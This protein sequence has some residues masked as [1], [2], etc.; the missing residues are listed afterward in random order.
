MVENEEIIND[1]SNG[2]LNVGRTFGLQEAEG[3]AAVRILSDYTLRIL[4]PKGEDLEEAHIRRRI[5][6]V[7]QAVVHSLEDHSLGDH[8]LEFC[9]PSAA[10]RR[11]HVNERY[12]CARKTRLT[13]T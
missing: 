3:R 4:L 10:Q 12:S 13:Q 9:N 6:A 11:R 2:A 7:G 8:I 5:Q 1:T